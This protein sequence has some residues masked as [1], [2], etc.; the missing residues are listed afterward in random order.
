MKKYKLAILISHPIQYY[1]PLYQ[2]LE[3]HSQID[4]T[5]YFCWNGG[6]EEGGTFERD[7]DT[8]IKWDLPILDGY[9]HIFLKNYAWT[10]PPSFWGLINP[11]ILRELNHHRYDAIFIWGYSALSNWLAFLA[12]GLTHTPVFLG[13]SA[14]LTPGNHPLKKRIKKAIL[15]PLFKRVSAFMC[16]CEK[17]AEFFRYY[18]AM[19]E[20]IYWNPAAVNNRFFQNQAE[21]LHPQRKE[22]KK[23]LDIPENS[24]VI[25]FLGK[26]IPLKNVRDLLMAF[27]RISGET[28]AT[29]LI[30][31]SGGERENLER[32][33][34]ENNM[35]RVIFTG[36]KNQTELP[37]YYAISDLLVVPSQID[38]SPRVIN[39]AMN[40][41]LPIIASN[42]VGT[43][44]DLVR[45][46]R[47]GY[48]FSVGDVEELSQKLRKLLFD[49][50]LRREMGR[51]SRKIIESWTYQTGVVNIL[52]ALSA[53]PPR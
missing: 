38:F 43:R 39:E 7:F 30:V 16:E 37:V 26:L 48:I 17:N 5:V 8:K 42:M 3:A 44:G 45:D 22:I 19:P 15:N 32:F 40:Y 14:T 33:V 31:G 53:L 20:N 36:F 24:P 6:V 29:L 46:E 12:A 51:A 27:Q 35:R 21:E 1:Y 23:S 52:K 11:A 2:E 10:S 34:R 47:N 41:G 49:P 18:G 9:H 28:D 50:D 25:L 4:L 13:G